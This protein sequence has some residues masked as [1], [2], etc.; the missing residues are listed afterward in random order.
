MDTNVFYQAGDT[1]GD[2]VTVVA[3]QAAI[4]VPHLQPRAGDVP[5]WHRLRLLR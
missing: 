1:N 2:F 5:A 4:A 3:P